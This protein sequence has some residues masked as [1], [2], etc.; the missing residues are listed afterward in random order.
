MKTVNLFVIAMLI[1][2]CTIPAD[3]GERVDQ[4]VPVP[5]PGAVTVQLIALNSVT[6]SWN[7]VSGAASY[8][9]FRSLTGEDDSFTR[10]KVTQEMSW[11]DTSL[12][13]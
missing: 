7:P 5:V 9:V 4:D 1:S 12:T 3:F 10:V 2:S 11:I 13:P 8:S 6:I